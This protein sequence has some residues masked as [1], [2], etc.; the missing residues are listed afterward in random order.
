MRKQRSASMETSGLVSHHSDRREDLHHP[1]RR[2]ACMAVIATLAVSA[3][4][5]GCSQKEG[6]G[7][8]TAVE[9]EAPMELRLSCYLTGTSVFTDTDGQ[10]KTS[11]R[12]LVEN[13]DTE[14]K[15][16]V[17]G[18]NGKEALVTGDG[19]VQVYSR[20]INDHCR[21][22]DGTVPGTVDA[23][24]VTYTAGTFASSGWKQAGEEQYQEI[25]AIVEDSIPYFYT[26]CGVS[27]GLSG[28]RVMCVWLAGF[29]PD[30]VPVDGERPQLKR[31]ER[32]SLVTA[33]GGE[34]PGWEGMKK[35]PQLSV[36]EF[37][38]EVSI[39]AEDADTL[40]ASIAG[41]GLTLRHE[42]EDGTIS[43]FELEK[44]GARIQ[45]PAAGSQEDTN[46]AEEATEAAETAGTG[47]DTEDGESA[48]AEDAGSND[49]SES[50]DSADNTE[51]PEGEE[52]GA[53]S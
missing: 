16:W 2:M 3:P 25:G 21:Y 51:T 27:T 40:L 11:V 10:E 18:L 43:D 32:F 26:G 28:E 35:E 33:D 12:F 5:A 6:Q 39:Q 52:S 49:V 17:K 9:T 47:E 50:G 45:E 29:T 31:A 53:G 41:T 23:D 1:A 8:G 13:D 22:V 42:S 48:G 46:K 34:I 38:V 20:Y 15:D 30:S 19:Q 37:G 14:N 36:N 44:K 24:D 7:Q 4:L